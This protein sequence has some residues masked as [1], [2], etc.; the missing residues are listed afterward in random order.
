M[1]AD[2]SFACPFYSRRFALCLLGL[3]VATLIVTA[4]A[5]GQVEGFTEPFRSIELSSDESGA[6]ASLH[7]EEGDFIEKNAIVCKLDTSVQEIQ[8]EIARH[9][10]E[11]TSQLKAA[12]ETYQKR[13]AINNRIK[14]LLNKGHATDSE[15][16]RSDMELSIAN[17]RLLSARED[18]QVRKIEHQRALIQ[19]QRRTIH[20]PFAG[21]VS[22]VHRREGEFLS[23]LHPEVVSLIQID[24]LLARFN[25]PSSQVGAFEP[26]RQFELELYSGEKVIGTVYSIG[27]RTEAQSGTVEIKLVIDNA[28]GDLRAGEMLTL[29]I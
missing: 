20:A 13:L 26:G 5:D 8:V 6:I 10:A 16:L 9:L 14:E 18:L 21:V 17:A 23:P 24:R 27:V 28:D 19:L 1:N 15:L 25:V 29:K 2:F 22:K 11:S 3:C 12:Q 4:V 7:V